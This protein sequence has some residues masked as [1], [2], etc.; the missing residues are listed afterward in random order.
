MNKAALIA[1]LCFFIG[2]LVG[3]AVT[4]DFARCK[5]NDVIFQLHVP[6][7]NHDAYSGH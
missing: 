1:I 6:T 5:T 7:E 3:A 2:A 4:Y